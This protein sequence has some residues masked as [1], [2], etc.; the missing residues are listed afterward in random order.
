MKSLRM[1]LLVPIISTIAII[2]LCVMA[3][4]YWKT[5][6][7][8]QTNLVERFQIQTQE[9]ANAFDIRMQREKLVMDS[10]GKQGTFQFSQLQADRQ[11]QFSFLKRMHDD[12][13]QW[14]PVSFLPDLSGKD[15]ATSAETG[16][17]I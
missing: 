15:V 16:G 2:L 4:S 10:F 9:L 6:S 5:S 8:L 7:I 1:Q 13:S 11:L 12:Y 14:N 17:C 3:I